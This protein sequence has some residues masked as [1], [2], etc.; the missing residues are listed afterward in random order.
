MMRI[1]GRKSRTGEAMY[2]AAIGLMPLTILSSG[3]G[4]LQHVLTGFAGA[5]FVLGLVG[6]V[7]LRRSCAR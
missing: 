5:I 3:H 2:W 4:R 6:I 7:R 1:D